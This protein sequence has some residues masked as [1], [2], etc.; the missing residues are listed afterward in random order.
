MVVSRL[1]EHAVF[2]LMNPTLQTC[3]S[4]LKI[5]PLVRFTLLADLGHLGLD[6]IKETTTNLEETTILVSVG[7][8]LHASNNLIELHTNPH[9]TTKPEPKH[10]PHHKALPPKRC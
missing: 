3:A 2:A 5:L 9:K 1:P 6:M 4:S 10:N 7:V 8:I